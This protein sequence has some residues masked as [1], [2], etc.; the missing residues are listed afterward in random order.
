MQQHVPL[1]LLLWFVI[2]Q[3]AKCTEISLVGFTVKFSSDVLV[4]GVSSSVQ[5]STLR[6]IYP[7]RGNDVMPLHTLIESAPLYS[8]TPCVYL[9]DCV[10]I[11][12]TSWEKNAD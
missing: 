9:L 2:L 5:P 7:E 4:Y 10:L 12:L 3:Q 8:S 1:S 11:I 6:L